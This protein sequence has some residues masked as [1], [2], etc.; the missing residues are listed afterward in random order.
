MLGSNLKYLR[1][2]NKLT[3][4]NVASVIGV[5][6]STYNNYE[7][8]KSNPPS[9]IL[10]KIAQQFSISVDDLL[11]KNFMH[12]NSYEQ[13]GQKDSILAKTIRILPVTVTN[14]GKES[15]EFV[16][17][18]A[19]AGY[20]AG[21][22][23]EQYI[24]DLPRFYIPK[25]AKGTYRAFEIAGNSMPPI[26]DGY[27]VIGRYVEQINHLKYGNRYI[28]ALR[29]EGVVF[30]K[31]IKESNQEKVLILASDNSEFSP[32]SV[33]LGD[34]LEAWEFVAFIG[35]PQKI[36]MNYFILDKLHSIE[37]KLGLFNSTNS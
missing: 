24:A 37:Q 5:S 34:V 20:V 3:Q 21:M 9:N 2:K 18:K 31:I 8:A 15:I 1:E 17:T 36:D 25:L 26:L 19:I 16:P 7:K 14:H 32:Y 10:L 27:I 30:K 6:R 23:T 33:H 35:F 4:E 29:N 11:T 28:L 12:P 22:R 13:F